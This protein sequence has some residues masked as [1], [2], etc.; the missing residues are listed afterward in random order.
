MKAVVLR[1]LGKPTTVEKLTLRP[2]DRHEV[3]VRLAASGV[4]HSDLSLRDGSIPPLLPCTLGHEGAGVVR[5][6]R[7]QPVIE[8]LNL[9]PDER[10]KA[11][12]EDL[13]DRL[14]SGVKITPLEPMA[15][16]QNRQFPGFYINVTFNNGQLAQQICSEITSMFL[17]ENAKKRNDATGRTVLI[18]CELSEA[19]YA[20]DQVLAYGRDWRLPRSKGSMTAIVEPAPAE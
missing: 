16:T 13:V 1:E 4:C 5:S 18:T 20:R 7:L 9:Y 10:G 17:A 12:M 15:G 8:K 19:E 11:H 3:R 2:L 6:Q 14:R